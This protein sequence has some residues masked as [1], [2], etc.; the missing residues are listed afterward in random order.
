HNAQPHNAI[1]RVFEFHS[2][3]IAH[4]P[5]F[6]YPA[7]RRMTLTN[8]PQKSILLDKNEGVHPAGI[9]FPAG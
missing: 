3:T 4:S 8:A 6:F 1:R 2:K 5:F 7:A 9:S